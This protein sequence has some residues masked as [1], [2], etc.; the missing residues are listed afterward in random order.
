MANLNGTS[1]SEP[2]T[3]TADADVINS[4]TPPVSGSDTVLGLGGDDV[5]Y[6][7]VESGDSGV[8]D[9]IDGG[10]GN[11]TIHFD[12]DRV[13]GLASASLLG[14]AGD[15]YIVLSENFSG[16]P[17]T[18][19]ILVDGGAGADEIVLSGATDPLL[20][21]LSLV[22]VEQLTL[23]TSTGGRFTTEQISAISGH[24]AFINPPP[25]GT[26]YITYYVLLTDGGTAN[27]S[28][29]QV[30]F[31][32]G[33]NIQAVDN[34]STT[35]TGTTANDSIY[36]GDA[37]SPTTGVHYGFYGGAG[38]D[39]LQVGSTTLVASDT[40]DGGAG[41]DTLYDASN[42]AGDLIDGGAGVDLAYV[43]LS[44]APGLTLHLDD[45]AT[46]AGVTFADHTTVRNVE[47]VSLNLTGDNET[48]YAGASGSAI[49]LTAGGT[50]AYSGG[51][52]DTLQASDVYITPGGKDVVSPGVGQTAHIDYSAATAPVHMSSTTTYVP[53]EGTTYN[54][55]AWIG[56]TASS[57]PGA[58]SSVTFTQS[59]AEVFGSAYGDTLVTDQH[60]D[61]PASLEV[62]LHGGLGN[63]TL[64][65]GPH[66]ALL[67]GGDG[68][69]TVNYS[70]LGLPSTDAGVP[71]PS[72]VT[73]TL[74]VADGQGT[75]YGV[76]TI[77]GVENVV[78][79]V[80]ADQLTGD[81][82]ANQ[83]F[84]GAGDDTLSGGAGDDSLA[85]GPGNDVLFGGDGDDT[86]VFN[87][88]SEL[89][90]FQ[91]VGATLVVTG[92][93][94]SDTLF[95]IE[96]LQFADGVIS[97]HEDQPMPVP[98]PGI[99]V[100]GHGLITGGSSTLR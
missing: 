56:G 39:L 94:G 6:G 31:A 85:G 9:R 86:A 68:I 72:G 26:Q 58:L 63:D 49:Y 75:G 24:L 40:L 76:D 45:F 17:A 30:P 41:N 2:L 12:I 37:T 14:G 33:M 99:S 4:K 87:F 96:H 78:G 11:D 79:T 67:D 54:N 27:L 43:A 25:Y 46:A 98:A 3:G 28:A 95:G 91:H 29:A 84:G 74:G 89:A 7:G 55:E 59:A 48:V 64:F 77:I 73:V 57:D 92:P 10:D 20:S 83:L 50:K 13:D 32:K 61:G 18:G 23:S 38:D 51:G 69:D 82:G 35:I 97:G 8:V 44:E 90:G 93:D 16:N 15:D 36:G 53:H 42:A 71:L 52:N 1:A 88:G 100:S 60:A 21:R 70:L 65:A 5:V 62:D 47:Q 66:G 34:A 22:G 81:A 80:Q 19:T